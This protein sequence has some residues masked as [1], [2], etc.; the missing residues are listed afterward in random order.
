MNVVMTGGADN[1]RFA[2]SLGHFLHPAR[3]LFPSF[4]FEVSELANVVNLYVRVRSTEFTFVRK[5]SFDEFV[6]LM[7]S[8]LREGRV[9]IGQDCLFL[10][11]Q[12]YASE[13]CYQRFLS[14]CSFHYDL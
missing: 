4:L 10:S 1:Q 6:G 5:E 7:T 12:W 2:P 8:L 13:L 9:E 3:F 14:V 11:S